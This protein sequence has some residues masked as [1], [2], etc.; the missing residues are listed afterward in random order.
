MKIGKTRLLNFAL[1]LVL[2]ASFLTACGDETDATGSSS[3]SNTSVPTLDPSNAPLSSSKSKQSDTWL[4]ILYQ[5]GD[6]EVLEED[7]FIDLNEAEIVGSTDQVK[8]VSQIDRYD[9]GFDG[10]GDWT[11]AKRFL[12]TKDNDLDAIHSKELADLGEVDSGNPETLVDYVTWAIRAYPSDH[13]VL[14][15]GDHG[16]GWDGGWTDDDPVEGS[17]FHMQDIDDALGKIIAK[18]GIGAFELVGF[19]ACLMGQLEVMSA[20]A[21]HARYAVASE[22]TEPAIGWAY[23]SFLKALN[24]NPAMT[25]KELGKA[26]VDSYIK[27]DFRITDDDARYIYAEGDY[28]AKSVADDMLVDTTLSTVDLGQMQNLNAAVNDLA[29]ALKGVDQKLVSKARTYAQSYTSVFEDKVPPSYIDLGHFV[30]L[31][32]EKVDDPEV[33]KAANQ[34]QLALKKAVTSETHGKERPGSNG[35]SIFF[36]TSK[37]YTTTFGK[38]ADYRYSKNVGRFAKASL[39]DDFLTYHY[40]DKD[41]KSTGADLTVLKPAASAQ[42][43]FSQAVEDA[44]PKPGVEVVAPGDGKISIKPIKVS[45]KKI[46]P[47][48][49]VKMTTEITGGNVAYVYYYV[50][51]YDAEYGSYLTAD[52]GYISAETTREIGGVY[53]PDWGNGPVIPIEYTWE[54]TLYY[55]SDG[56]S[57]NDQFAFFEPETYGV[58]ESSNTYLVNGVYTFKKSGKTT[59]AA[60]RF[61]G[62]GEMQNIFSFNGDDG[63][64]APHEITPQKGDKFTITEEWLEFDVNPDGEFTDYEGG[65]MTYGKNGFTMVPYYAYSGDYIV[66]IVVMDMNGNSTEDFVEITV[67][68]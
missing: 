8:I 61:N 1:I 47:D 15:L 13:Y 33:V 7:T 31:I 11:T 59:D 29:I 44:A 26:I 42:D 52:M 20:I 48:G 68:E 18:T 62:D 65:T 12:I 50:S 66:G 27:Q 5:N 17:Y 54:P 41:F 14:I 36:P 37:L 38:N 67:T 9:G 2:M 34:V 53:Y 39:W 57:A 35:L 63:G 25:G 23:S 46:G 24:K 49:S 43:D 55:M 22:E 3:P 28:T 4:V 6:D 40:T 30:D 21:P 19:D 45:K 64:G 51:Y 10:D 32:L 56:K 58:D 16:A 60:I